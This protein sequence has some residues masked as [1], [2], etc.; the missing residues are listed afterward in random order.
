VTRSKRFFVH[1]VYMD[2]SGVD[3]ESPLALYGALIVTDHLFPYIEALHTISVENLISADR[4]DDF[5]EFHAYELFKG[6]GAFKG[7]DESARFNAIRS[8]LAGMSAN[9]LPYIYSAVDKEKVASVPLFG[10]ANPLDVAFQQCVLGV[11][12]W[13]SGQE[14]DTQDGPLNLAFDN[15]C[16]FIS[17]D[18]KDEKLKKHLRKS[19]R[20]FRQR[21]P[22]HNFAKHRLWHGHDDMFFGDSKYSV[23]IQIVDL[24]SYFM[25]RHLTMKNDPVGD[26]FFQMFRHHAVCPIVDPS[27]EKHRD[28]FRSHCAVDVSAVTDAAV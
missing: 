11:E 13:A 14:P 16:L 21:R 7:L 17:D 28:L 6:D 26:E 3:S 25:L 19:Y 8:L 12:A 2:E 5:E 9:G 10:S 23:G 18:T 24:C 27:W 4:R 15:L 1:I 20:T 22:I